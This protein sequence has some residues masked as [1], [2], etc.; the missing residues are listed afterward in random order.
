[1]KQ[2]SSGLEAFEQIF[3]GSAEL[4]KRSEAVMAGG[5]AH[6]LW[7]TEPFPVYFDR[8]EGPYKWDRD[9][10]RLIDFWL[11]HGAHLCGHGFAP[12]IEAAADRLRLGTHL[13]S[14]TEAPIRWAEAICALVPSA[15]RVRFTS[16]GTEATMMALRVSRAYTERDKVVKFLGH[17][18]GW[19][20]EVLADTPN[21]YAG[22]RH[23]RS[24]D[25]VEL[26]S[27]MD[28][29][30]VC[31]RL[32]S[33][34]VAAVIL[35]PGGGSSGALPWSVESLQRLREATSRTGTM[36]IFDEVV[37]GF[38][39]SPGGVQALVGVTPDLTV[40]GKILGG[41][42]PGAAVAGE[43]AVMRVFGKGIPRQ[44]NHAR[45]MHTGTFNGNV[46][47]ATAGA[48]M[49]G[50]I[51]DGSHQRAAES[52]CEQ[53]VAGINAAAESS[54]VDLF[55]YRASS[56]FHVLIGPRR[57]GVPLGPSEA[58][59][60]LQNRSDR[61]YKVL[62]KAL[63]VEG[64]DCHGS[65]GWTSSAHDAEVIADTVSGFERALANARDEIE[66]CIAGSG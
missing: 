29:D 40:L 37:S 17:F 3:A 8:A 16:S 60:A 11:G 4:T 50:A 43:A 58:G 23:P 36:L 18:H 66:R 21:E 39:Y 51:G 45:V 6:D 34:D 48:A 55:A 65:H 64:V 47:S 41:G 52:A 53:L 7:A 24:R 28:I 19:H 35:E 20:D 32:E 33:G 31:R 30:G 1:M 14:P 12:V 13:T 25:F 42:F 49:L 2:A 38:R 44:S 5:L 9:G 27:C 56:V 62:R 61:G 46:L 63:L 26:P 57:H 15:E 59:F 10:N 54:G 22:G